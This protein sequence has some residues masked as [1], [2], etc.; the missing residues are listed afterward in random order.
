MP[1]SYL[2][3]CDLS[4]RSSRMVMRRPGFR[5]AISRMRLESTS[6]LKS[7]ASSTVESGLKVTLVPRSEVVPRTWTFP[8]GTPFSYRCLWICPPR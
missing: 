6:K 8:V 1:P 5:K 3:S 2:K 7:V 4:V